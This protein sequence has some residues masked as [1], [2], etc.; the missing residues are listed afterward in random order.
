MGSTKASSCRQSYGRMLIE[1]NLGDPAKR[2]R[3]VSDYE[4]NR[5][6]QLE[7]SEELVICMWLK[8]C[9]RTGLPVQI[10]YKIGNRPNLNVV[11]FRLFVCAHQ[12]THTP[13]ARYSE[14]LLLSEQVL[15]RHKSRRLTA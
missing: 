9:A 4:S 6:S 7:P 5:G 15:E 13:R 1:Q 10:L 2:G 11:S 3:S 14:E 12:E 8:W